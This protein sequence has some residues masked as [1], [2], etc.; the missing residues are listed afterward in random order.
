MLCHVLS[1]QVCRSTC[2]MKC[3]HTIKKVQLLQFTQ[4]TLRGTGEGEGE[5]LELVQRNVAHGVGS[6]VLV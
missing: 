2:F 5:G 6:V 4:S 1:I 3:K